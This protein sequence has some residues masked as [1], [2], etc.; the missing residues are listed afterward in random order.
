MANNQKYSPEL[1]KTIGICRHFAFKDKSDWALMSA[2]GF[3]KWIEWNKSVFPDTTLRHPLKGW[4]IC[5]TSDLNRAKKTA[6]MIVKDTPVKKEP[7]LREVPFYHLNIPL[8]LPKGAWLFLSR[9]FWLLGLSAS[10]IET[11]K[12]VKE[13]AKKVSRILNKKKEK[14]ILVITHGFFAHFLC[15]ELKRLGFKG[16]IPAVPEYGKIYL[17]IK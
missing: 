15:C 10:D 11:K 14:K 17:F 16:A 9:L 3:N 4:D 8:I 1:K 12:Q 13:R 6:C 5:L 2:K 7:L